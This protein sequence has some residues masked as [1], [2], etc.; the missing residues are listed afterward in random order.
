MVKP[1]EGKESRRGQEEDP[2][3]ARGGAGARPPGGQRRAAHP[4][5]RA[6]TAGRA[7]GSQKTAGSV[8]D[9][10]SGTEAR[11]EGA[12]IGPPG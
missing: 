3:R 9:A 8:P 4:G 6:A 5:H 1:G 10:R 7:G 2:P 11:P 12:R